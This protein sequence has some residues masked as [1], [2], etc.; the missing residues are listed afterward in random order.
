MAV[1]V[2]AD[3]VLAALVVVAGDALLEGTDVAVEAVLGAAA[4][5]VGAG[6]SGVAIATCADAGSAKASCK[7]SKKDTR[8]ASKTGTPHEF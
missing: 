7:Q 2:L 1:T 6:D 3:A 8:R 4:E 5:A